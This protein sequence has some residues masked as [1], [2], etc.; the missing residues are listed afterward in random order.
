M[1]AFNARDEAAKALAAENAAKESPTRT[2]PPA[3]SHAPPPP[4]PPKDGSEARRPSAAARNMGPRRSSGGLSGQYSTS[5]P[6]TGG[7]FPNQDLI[8]D[9]DIQTSPRY[10]RKQKDEKQKALK[11]AWGIDE[12]E[13]QNRRCAAQVY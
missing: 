1:H 3:I 12:R 13:S 4:V 6:T 10:Q 2:G 5:Y 7:Y 11:A 9:D 8:P